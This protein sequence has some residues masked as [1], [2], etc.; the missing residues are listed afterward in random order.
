[1]KL[2]NVRV[3]LRMGLGFG[4]LLLMMLF[5]GLYAVSRVNQVQA[6]V[7]DLSE[8]WLPSTQQLG[9]IN[10]SLNQ[11]RRAELQM[12]LGGG[13]KAIEDEGAR[14]AKQWQVLPPLLKSYG[15]SLSSEAERQQFK[16]FASIID[17]YKSSQNKLV[18][19]VKAGQQEEALAYLRGESR[20][21]FRSTADA[22]GKLTEINTA[23]AK[24]AKADAESSYKSVLWGIWLMVAV[25]MGLGGLVAWLM[26]RSLTQPLREAADAA[27]RIAGG[28]LSAD[29]QSARGDELGDLLRCLARMQEALNASVS[30]VR[31]SADY[32]AEASREVSS[33]SADL[34]ARTEQAASNLEETSAAMQQLTESA[35]NS[36]AS[37][38]EA[39]RL[40][41]TASTVAEQGGSMVAKVVSTM[42]GIQQSSRKI[43]DIIGVIDG[44]AFQTNILA[45][46]AAVEAARA[47]EQGRGFAVVAGEVRTLA[48]RSAQAAREIKALISSSVEQVEAGNRQV[49]DAGSTMGEV[50]DSV[51]RVTQLIA[52]IANAVQNQTGSLSE[53][54]TAVTQ[55]DGMTQQ[56]AA[57]VEESAA[58]SESLREQASK[59]AEVVARFRLKSV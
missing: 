3:G 31:Y 37:A 50:V 42:D 27:D 2:S 13:A 49:A 41:A 24:A 46:N 47:G 38:L 11:M 6:N 17:S 5:M 55:L 40:A 39:S 36:A 25:A 45:L 16:E 26:T 29:V 56:N 8:N 19:M 43:S 7:T 9:G 59:L 32:I 34:S 22:I 51:R 53:V 12:L 54:N 4:A 1:M 14:L 30:T 23:G 21:V 10:E 35:R 20:K 28:D 18:D 58:A 44:I 52:E 48:Q 57:L 15:E 33:G